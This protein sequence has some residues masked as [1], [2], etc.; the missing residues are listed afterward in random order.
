MASSVIS[1]SST[2]ARAAGGSRPSEGVP[3]KFPRAVPAFERTGLEAGIG[4]A[5]L[6]DQRKGGAARSIDPAMFQHLLLLKTAQRKPGRE[7]DQLLG[8][9]LHG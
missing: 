3:E 8:P 1:R 4:K 7:N 5:L 9:L 2:S 6:L